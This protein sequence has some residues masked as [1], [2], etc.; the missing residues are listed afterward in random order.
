VKYNNSVT[1]KKIFYQFSQAHAQPE[2]RVVERYMMAQN[3][4]SDALTC[5]LGFFLTYHFPHQSNPPKTDQNL[6]GDRISHYK[7]K[8][9]FSNM[10]RHENG[11]A[12]RR[13]IPKNF[14]LE[15]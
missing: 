14:R 9:N 7:R 11:D 5:F 6:T 8:T 15:S 12:P 10:Q 3:A 1:L 13:K 2:R 4:C